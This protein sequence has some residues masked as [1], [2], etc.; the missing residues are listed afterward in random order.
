MDAD[1][2]I[3]YKLP[4]VQCEGSHKASQASGLAHNIG[5][6]GNVGCGLSKLIGYKTGI[7]I[8]HPRV[9]SFMAVAMAQES[10][11]VTADWLHDR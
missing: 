7:K 8:N 11:L 6:L 2:N 10:S 1:G 3:K 9:R 4:I 5:R